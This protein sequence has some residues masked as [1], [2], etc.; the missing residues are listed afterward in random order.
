MTT[1]ST[2]SHDLGHD[3]RHGRRDDGP[4]NNPALRV[5]L[6]RVSDRRRPVPVRGR[7]TLRDV[8][9]RAGVSFKTVSRVV[10]GESGV[11][12]STAERVLAAVAELGYHPDQ[13]ARNLR[14]GRTRAIGFLLVD[15]A[16]P[17][18]S[19]LLRGIEEVARTHGMAV[20]AGSTNG[21]AKRE[22][23]LISDFMERR[24]EGLLVVPTGMNP[25]LFT[26]RSRHGVPI[27]VLDR[28]PDQPGTDVVRSDHYGG[29]L[30]AIRHLID[31]GHRRIAFFGDDIALFSAGERHRAYIDALAATSTDP[32]WDHAKW[33]VTA[34]HDAD[35]WA[36][37]AGEMLRDAS[38]RPTAIFTAQNF[39]TIGVARSLHALGLQR[40]LAHIGFDDVELADVVD[41]A[42]SVVPQ[43]PRYLGVRAA[44]VLF[45]RLSGWDGPTVHEVVP[46]HVVA[47][48]SGEIRPP[49]T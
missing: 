36:R 33:C 5:N 23:E 39:V 31:R 43:D 12:T 42:L 22:R 14:G 30:A 24:V 13:Q 27:V 45:E 8:A 41:P 49:S 34:S 26:E 2:R 15:V 35:T 47:R 32:N 1:L 28:E 46:C 9:E 25:D 16:N 4:S 10:N 20:L 3:H 38:D 29:A 18:F 21:S 19:Q 11:S 44:D 40:E 6:L 48:G 37:L 17:F 7:P